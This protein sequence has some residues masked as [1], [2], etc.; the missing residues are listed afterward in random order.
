[1]VDNENGGDQH[2]KSTKKSPSGTVEVL[3][4]KAEG[5]SKQTKWQH[6]GVGGQCHFINKGL[7]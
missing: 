4:R 6:M 7:C 3:A 2:E 5:G 1:M